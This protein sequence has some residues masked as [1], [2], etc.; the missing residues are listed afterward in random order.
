MEH[1]QYGIVVCFTAFIVSILVALEQ[2]IIHLHVHT[3][4]CTTFI[5]AHEIVLCT[6]T[7]LVLSMDHNQQVTSE[8]TFVLLCSSNLRCGEYFNVH[9]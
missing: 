2:G 8:E 9:M 5:S 7:L 4:C 6:F 1:F 3:H